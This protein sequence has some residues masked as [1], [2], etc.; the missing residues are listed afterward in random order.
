MT[1]SQ[2][3]SKIYFLTKTNVTSLPNATM[4]ILIN[5]AYERVA[6]LI[7]QA[8]SRWIWDDNN[9]TDFPIA[10]TSLVSGQQDYALAVSHIK[11]QRVECAVD[12]SASNWIVLE[13]YNQEDEESALSSLAAVSGTPFRYDQIGASILLDPKP[14]FNCTNGL[15]LYFQRG[16]TVFT[17]GDLSTGTAVPGFNSLY[18]DLISL[19]CSYDYAVANGL[20][21]ANQ[22]FIEI[23]RKEKALGLDY[24]MRLKDSKPRLEIRQES[25]K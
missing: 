5:N 18:H 13:H 24:A 14:N 15:K 1:L 21:N 8:D 23:D 9:N 4:L 12:S 7:M 16:P 19:W 22:I 6:S 25:N 11:I 20:K 10:T 3:Q 17:S 2:I